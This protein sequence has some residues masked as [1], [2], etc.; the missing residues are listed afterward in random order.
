MAFLLHQLLPP[1][2]Q[3]APDKE[4]VRHKG[5]AL[6]YAQLETQSNQ[7]AT[8]LQQLG[9]VPGDRVGI[10]LPKS[11]AAIV[12]IFG[13]LKAGAVYVPLDP[14]APPARI[15]FMV[16]NCAM[17]GIVT[18]K[19]KLVG[20]YETAV[21]NLTT[22]RGLIVTDAADDRFPN[23]VTWSEM[24]TKET[25]LPTPTGVIEQD[26][27]YILYTSGSTGTPKGVM[28]SHRAA[29][30]FV[31]WAHQTFGFRPTDRVSNHAPLHFDLSILD[32]FATIK[33]GGTVVL[34]PPSLSVF[35]RNLADFIA[36]ERIT[37]WYSVPSALTRLVL[38]GELARHSYPDLRLILFAGEVFPIKYLRDLMAL[39]PQPRYF[40]LFGPTETNV[41]T[42]YEVPELDAERTKPLSI[43]RSCENFDLFVLDEHDQLAPV[44]TKGELCARGPGVMSGYWGLPERTAQAR[45]SYT[46]HP[47]LGPEII[48]R[49]GDIVCQEAD[50]TYTYLGRHDGM[51]KSRGYRIELG[52]VEAAL[53]AH[54]D[55]LETAVIPIPDDEIGNRLH[56]FVVIQNGLTI[57]TLTA[58]CAQHIPKY[59]VPHAIEL[60][61]TLPK[62]STGKIDKT[63]LK[64]QMR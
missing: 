59:M 7:L 6:T 60:R 14:T 45:I 21:S 51:V 4:A 11:L 27:A 13:I 52:E 8:T 42:Y 3:I 26:L 56:A 55:V 28:I 30:T 49:T 18:E 33:A 22:L 40:N 24:I 36:K 25:T 48:Y 12:A 63:T 29:L 43:G 10:Y 37:I 20:L 54:P 31:D 16:G 23:A 46:R 19:A 5:E 1:H 41:C 50:G 64:T 34:V 61:E 15:A 17:K 53:Y 62:T 38:Y 58:F 35:P 2:A 44:G 47:M 57:A 39:L 32:I 9:V